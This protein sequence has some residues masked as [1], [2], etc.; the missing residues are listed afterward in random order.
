MDW[1]ALIVISGLIAAAIL[2][3]ATLVL[4]ANPQPGAL[5][6]MLGGLVTL[7]VGVVEIATVGIVWTGPGPWQVS[8]PAWLQEFSYIVAGAFV[9]GIALRVTQPRP[10]S[11]ITGPHAV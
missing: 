6:A 11:Q 7:L 9:V 3:A 2:I 4:I 1:T 8:Q 5:P 10:A